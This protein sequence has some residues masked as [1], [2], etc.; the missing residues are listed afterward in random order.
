MTALMTL[1]RNANVRIESNPIPVA[2]VLI[3]VRDWSGVPIELRDHADTIIPE[4][5]RGQWWTVGQFRTPGQ[6]RMT[7]LVAKR[8]PGGALAY[9]TEVQ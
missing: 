5:S 2:G 6:A 8:T 3:R 9:G 1:A 4:S 7:W